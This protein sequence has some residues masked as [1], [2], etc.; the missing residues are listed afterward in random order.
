M[1][2]ADMVDRDRTNYRGRECVSHV[3][4]AVLITQNGDGCRR[5]LR[6]KPMTAAG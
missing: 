6:S 5:Q 1:S 4:I 3:D 2:P